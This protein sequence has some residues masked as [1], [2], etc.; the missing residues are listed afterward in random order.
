MV[1]WYLLFLLSN[2]SFGTQQFS[3]VSRLTN[4]TP[5]AE[6]IYSVRI[7]YETKLLCSKT[8]PILTE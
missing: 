4:F 1:L 3:F 2:T 5:S 6:L 8:V 7:R